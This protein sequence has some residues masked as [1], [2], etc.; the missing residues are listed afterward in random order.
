MVNSRRAVTGRASPRTGG[1]VVES[2]KQNAALDFQR[3]VF[4]ET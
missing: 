2:I 3:G 1:F 4:V